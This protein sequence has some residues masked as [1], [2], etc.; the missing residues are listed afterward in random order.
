MRGAGPR[1][2]G[3][4][5]GGPD[6]AGGAGRALSAVLKRRSR[7]PP[8]RP[9]PPGGAAAPAPGDT[10]RQNRGSVAAAPIPAPACSRRRRGHR[11]AAGPVPAL[12]GPP[13]DEGRSSPGRPVVSQRS[14]GPCRAGGGCSSA[15]GSGTWVSESP[16]Q[17]PHG[18]SWRTTNAPARPRG[19]GLAAL[20][21]GGRLK[22]ARVPEGPAA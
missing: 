13:E 22:G 20:T 9:A 3:A 18:P 16:G 19:P 8:G 7:L 11:G 21:G 10:P 15:T 5:P 4:T 14:P 1:C 6:R 12:P 17:G 2:R